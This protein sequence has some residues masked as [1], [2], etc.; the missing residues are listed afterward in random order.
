MVLC[1]AKASAVDMLGISAQHRHAVRASR[2][3]QRMSCH[4][5]YLDTS[6]YG[7]RPKLGWPI[8]VGGARHEKALVGAENKLM[9]FLL[10]KLCRKYLAVLW[11][12]SR[13]VKQAVCPWYCFAAVASNVD[14]IINSILAI[15]I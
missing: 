6:A 9:L 10:A 3:V 5:S 1:G 15:K 7:A 4:R 13:T 12:A 2:C 14:N 11:L 8:M